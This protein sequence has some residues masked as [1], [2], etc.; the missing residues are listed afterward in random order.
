MKILV[1]GS[2]GYIGR[3]LCAM[4]EEKN[5]EIHKLDYDNK[6]DS[7]QYN[8]DIRDAKE[9][10]YG[11]LSFHTYDAV[12]HLA[13]LVRVGESVHY[14]TLYY[15][16]NINGTLNVIQQIKFKKMMIIVK[17]P[18]EIYNYINSEKKINQMWKMS[19]V[20]YNKYVHP[21]VFFKKL[22]LILKNIK[23]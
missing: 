17:K 12:I 3:H 2:N 8:Y 6:V 22:D 20:Y 1:T 11:T 15:D 4:L 9:L 18:S 21:K 14:P 16:I 23:N 13:A 7:H 5:Y 19:N 10:R